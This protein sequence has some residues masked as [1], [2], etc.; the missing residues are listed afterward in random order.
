LIP[1]STGEACGFTDT[2][3]PGCSWSN[4]N[5]VTI[6]TIDAHEAWWPPTFSPDGFGRTRFA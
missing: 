5:E 4:H 6:D 3:S 1:C 2:R